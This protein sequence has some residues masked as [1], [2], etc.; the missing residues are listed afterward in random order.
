M[1]SFDPTEN[2]ARAR[3][4]YRRIALERMRPLSRRYDE[5]E[6]ALPH[7]W[8]EF[9]WNEGRK[10][11]PGN[12]AGQTDGFVQVCIQAEELCFGDAGLYLRM[13]TAALGGSAVSA[14]GT[15]G[16]EGP[17]PAAVPRIAAPDLGRDGDHRAERGLRLGRDPDHRALRRRARRVGAERHEDLLHGRRGRVADR[18]RLRRGVGDRRQD[19]RPRRDQVVRR[20]GAH[21]RA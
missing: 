10:G 15:P 4:F 12:I 14:A 18:G 1:I 16:A 7:E 5:D 19:A 20:S 13:P 2:S 17:L 8:V 21:A 3:E 6:H 9:Y 11:A